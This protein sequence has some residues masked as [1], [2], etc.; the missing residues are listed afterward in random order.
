MNIQKMIACYALLLMGCDSDAPDFEEAANRLTSRVVTPRVETARVDSNE[1][2]PTK[3]HTS[4]TPMADA[5]K[6]KVLM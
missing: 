2:C 6:S 5:F 4:W 1:L 3:D